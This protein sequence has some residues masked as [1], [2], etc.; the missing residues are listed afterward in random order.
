MKAEPESDHRSTPPQ[1]SYAE[2]LRLTLRTIAALIFTGSA[3][4]WLLFAIAQFLVLDIADSVGNLDA[5]SERAS[6]AGLALFVLSI[7]AICLTTGQFGRGR[8]VRFLTEAILV[9]IIA[10]SLLLYPTHTI[11]QAITRASAQFVNLLAIILAIAANY[12]PRKPEA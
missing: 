11:L 10:T 9:A 7:L 6:G 2:S 12:L 4:F 3:I 1:P 8:I 5:V